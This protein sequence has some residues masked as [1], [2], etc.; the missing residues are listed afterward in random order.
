MLL[1]L[2]LAIPLA[3]TGLLL[4]CRQPRAA[5]RAA[6]ALGG[7]EIAALA[8]LIWQVHLRG[9]LE[10]GSFLRVDGLSALILLVIA[11]ISALDL[12]Y[13]AG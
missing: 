12:V 8:L 9:P 6:L 4:L 3:A 10:A 1:L 5:I 13:A 7:L 11:F 2:T